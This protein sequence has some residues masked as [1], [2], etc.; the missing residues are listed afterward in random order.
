M[1]GICPGHA[2][3]IIPCDS[4]LCK[5]EAERSIERILIRVDLSEHGHASLRSLSAE[6]DMVFFEHAHRRGGC[7]LVPR[8]VPF[9]GW[10]W[11]ISRDVLHAVLRPDHTKDC[12][13]Q[14]EMYQHCQRGPCLCWGRANPSLE[15]W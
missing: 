6:R 1:D 14:L 10:Q 11:I 13:G 15:V 3:S 9:I 5:G 2:F 7:K 12:V 8:E 4:L